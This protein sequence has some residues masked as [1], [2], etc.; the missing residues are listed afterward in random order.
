MKK[1]KNKIVYYEETIALTPYILARKSGEGPVPYCKIGAE[2][3]ITVDKAPLSNGL[4]PLFIC[5]VS[6][7]HVTAAVCK[8]LN[9]PGVPS[10][11]E[12]FPVRSYFVLLLLLLLLFFFFFFF[13]FLWQ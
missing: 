9:T 12:Q 13:F 4:E 6:L 11:R 3:R 2:S 7:C 5:R 1:V 10:L 8:F